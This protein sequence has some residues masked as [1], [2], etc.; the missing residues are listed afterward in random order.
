V[1]AAELTAA[2][3]GGSSKLDAYVGERVQ[4]AVDAKL[5]KLKTR[6]AAVVRYVVLT[7][8]DNLWKQQLASMEQLKETVGY[9]AMGAEVEP[10]DLYRSRG[11]EIFNA[12]LDA[13]RRNAVYSL[14][15]YDPKSS[16]A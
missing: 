1:S 6:S 5:K 2:G 12:M 3:G 7:Q 16:A 8:Y 15:Q 14:F 4:A 13:V 11:L 9:L 10:I